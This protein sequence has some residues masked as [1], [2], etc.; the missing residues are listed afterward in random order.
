[1]SYANMDAVPTQTAG[2]SELLATDWNTYVRDNF[3][4][5][6]FGHVIVADDTA[7][8]ALGTVAEGTMVYQTDNNK[9]FVYNS[10]WVEVND[11]D[12]LGGLSTTVADSTRLL[13]GVMPI[14]SVLQVVR[15]SDSTNRTTT[16][17]SFVDASISVT[18]TPK[19]TS[20]YVMLIWTFN[21]SANTTSS[22][23]F[24]ISDSSNNAI[25]GAQQSFLTLV[26]TYGSSATLIG[27]VNPNTISAV[28]YKGR[29]RNNEGQT[30]SL[31]NANTTQQLFAI[32][33][34]V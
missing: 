7:K 14:G 4:S 6:K 26:S 32:E 8:T 13:S 24:R 27:W 9:V 21:F 23:V 19:A 25:S 12:I 11:L 33:V 31:S 2:T 18:I 22:A 10:G 30:T 20:N 17:T 1:M 15:A 28:T 5:I 16:S 3:D 34:A 29:F